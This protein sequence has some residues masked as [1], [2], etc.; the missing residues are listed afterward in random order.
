MGEKWFKNKPIDLK[1]KTPF[2]IRNRKKPNWAI[3]VPNVWL[4]DP[5]KDLAFLKFRNTQPVRDVL[6]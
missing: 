4:K 6:V 5:W 3:G 1:D 2:L